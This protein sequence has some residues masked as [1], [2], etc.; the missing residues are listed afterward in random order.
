MASWFSKGTASAVS[1]TK[2]RHGFTVNN[3]TRG[4]I[5]NNHTREGHGFSRAD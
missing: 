4:F 1:T 5:V 3:H 2:R